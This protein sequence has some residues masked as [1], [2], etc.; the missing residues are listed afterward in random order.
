M[1]PRN[2]ELKEAAQRAINGVTEGQIKI[3]ASEYEAWYYGPGGSI[4]DTSVSGWNIMALKLFLL[5][6]HKA[7]TVQ[8]RMGGRV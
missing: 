8:F 4:N 6:A 3:G 5:P 1:S 7:S 2:A